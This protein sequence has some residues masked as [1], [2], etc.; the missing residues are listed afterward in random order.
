MTSHVQVTDFEHFTEVYEEVSLHHNQESHQKE[1][2]RD[3]K[4]YRGQNCSNK[5]LHL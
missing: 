4:R 1:Q 3:L 5:I 2:P